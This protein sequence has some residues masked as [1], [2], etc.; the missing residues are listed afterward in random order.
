MVIG[1]YSHILNV[2]RKINAQKF[3]E[4]FY[5]NYSVLKHDKVYNPNIIDVDLFVKK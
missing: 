2:D 5:K 1:V 4:L 3:D